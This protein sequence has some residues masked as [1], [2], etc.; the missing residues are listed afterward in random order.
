MNYLRKRNLIIKQ[1]HAVLFLSFDVNS[2]IKEVENKLKSK[3]SFLMLHLVFE[4]LFSYIQGNFVF[5]Q[6]GSR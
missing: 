5:P 6:A 4:K 3:Q 2:H 1:E